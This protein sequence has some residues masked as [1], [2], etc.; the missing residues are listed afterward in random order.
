MKWTT[1]I[2]SLF[3][4]VACKTGNHQMILLKNLSSEDIFFLISKDKVLKNTD[5]IAGIRPKIPWQLVETK[6]NQDDK[7]EVESTKQSLF[8]YLVE[9][10]SLGVIL[11]S[12]SAEIF[13]DAVTIKSI[14]KDRF[15]GQ[16]NI[17]IITKNDLYKF[18]DQEILDQK[19][20]RFFKTLNTD[21]VNTDTLTLEYRHPFNALAY[22]TLGCFAIT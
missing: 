2:I 18:S 9:K 15:D 22:C 6:T 5:D 21:N 20:Y 19:M 3:V 10:D 11:T 12:G 4:F 1:F 7:E 17:F 13:L 8:R 16:V 14:I